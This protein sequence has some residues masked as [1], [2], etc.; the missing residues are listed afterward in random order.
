MKAG[1]A[2]QSC[3]MLMRCNCRS[4][5]EAMSPL[6][7]GRSMSAASMKISRIGAQLRRAGADRQLPKQFQGQ[8]GIADRS[9]REAA[10]TARP[11]DRPPT[12]P[13]RQIAEQERVGIDARFPGDP[14]VFEF[15]AVV[16]NPHR[17]VELVDD[18]DDPPAA[19]LAAQEG[20][21]R[22]VVAAVVEQ[23]VDVA[24][25]DHAPRLV[26]IEDPGQPG[27]ER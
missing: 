27:V 20:N 22:H 3:T 12:A 5:S 8:V 21:Q 6:P 10:R 24:A 26:G 13:C 9:P 18:A 4:L 11:A 1:S 7:A 16:E 19:A 25:E 23:V 2:N 15:L 17:A 14:G